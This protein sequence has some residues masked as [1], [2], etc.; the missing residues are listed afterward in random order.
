[1][2]NQKMLDIMAEVNKLA[3]EREELIECIALALLS[4][5]NLFILGDTGQAK[6]YCINEFRKRIRGAKQFE[7]LMSKQT[8]EEQL[9]GRINLASLIPGNLP[10]E[11]LIKD[12]SYAVLHNKLKSLFEQYEIDGQ[13]STLKEAHDTANQL[14]AVKRIACTLKSNAPQMVTEGK[15]PDSNIVFLDEIFKSNDG[16]LNSLLTALNERVYTNEGQTVN[17]PVISFFSASNEIPNFK[18]STQQIL[19]PLYDRFDLKVLT[20]YVEDSAN[21]MKILLD[22]QSNMVRKVNAVIS[23]SELEQMQREVRQVNVPEKINE[24]MDTVLCELRR[25][26]IQVSDRK[27]FGFAP[28]AQ[29]KAYLRGDSEVTSKDLLVLKNYF[30]NEPSEIPTVGRTLTD[31]CENP[32][33]AEVEKYLA[34]AYESMA[35]MEADMQADSENLKPYVKFSK[36][37]LRIYIDV[38]N[39]AKPDMN[40]A[41]LREIQTGEAKIEELSVK[42]DELASTS[43]VTMSERKRLN[44]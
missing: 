43:H 24:L 41:D 1:M 10:L 36:E 30:W 3:A 2:N 23:L 39:L 18:D 26:G 21:R 22:K 11:V 33:G 8:D 34:M 27:F 20:N 38:T 5:K 15:I 31:I 44:V 13:Q 32:I 7:R 12:T 19:K 4:R 25:C 40:N 17:I 28:I 37:L 9:F 6:S 29:A 16:I 14:E 42:A 35:E